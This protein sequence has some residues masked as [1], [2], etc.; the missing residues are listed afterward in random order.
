MKIFRFLCIGLL[1]FVTKTVF[2]GD[3][4]FDNYPANARQWSFLFYGG[5][6]ATQSLHDLIRFNFDSA[7][8]EVYSAELAY[9]LSQENA[10]SKFFHPLLDQIQF[11][12]NVAERYDDEASY[13]V[14]E[15]D[16]YLMV[17][18]TNRLW[19]RYLYTTMAVGEGVSYATSVPYVE[20]GGITGISST[21]FL[22]FMTFEITFALP[23]YPYFQVVTRIHH[24]S[25]CYGLF[26]PK[27]QGPGSNNI[28]VG[29]RYY[30][31]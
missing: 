22:D 18:R 21:R 14:T 17:R 5:V 27:D 24:R 15:F 23:S 26:Y 12:V 31:K 7:G 3:G 13:P 19:A 6:T 30:F 16:A 25:G 1:F 29:F 28:G 8:E 10:V 9:A 20:Q 4:W 11:A 2:A